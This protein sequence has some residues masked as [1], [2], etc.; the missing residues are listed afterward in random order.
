[1]KR[2]TTYNEFWPRYLAAHAHPGTRAL[3]YGGTAVAFVLAV[4]A[5][6]F[7]RW[8]PL[9]AAPMAGYGLSWLG[10][11]LFERNVPATFTHPLWSL[12]SGVRMLGL[13]LAGRLAH[14]MAKVHL[15]IATTTD[16]P[17]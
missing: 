1:M 11:A 17:E 9:A 5:A 13:W 8:E 14:E 6:A 10:H 16:Q 2:C 3:H 15:N 12:G 7:N 4:G